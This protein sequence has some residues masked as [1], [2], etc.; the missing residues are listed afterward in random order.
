MRYKFK[1]QEGDKEIEEKEGMS[2]KKTL[3]S[4][5]TL[6]PKWTGWI[7]YKNKKDKY[8]KHIILKGKKV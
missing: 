2:Y 1:I 4:L 3:K 8:V 7:A 5:V 6:N